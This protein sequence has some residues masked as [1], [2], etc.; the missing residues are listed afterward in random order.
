[1]N[2]EEVGPL[3]L[4]W[5]QVEESQSNRVM[6]TGAVLPYRSVTL[7][8]LYEGAESRSITYMVIVT[9]EH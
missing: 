2:C 8:G 5:V 9:A 3:T 7:M 6:V 1:M 4:I